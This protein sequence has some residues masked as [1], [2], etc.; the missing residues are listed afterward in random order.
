VPE[1]PRPGSREAETFT[2]RTRSW[3]MGP[4]DLLFLDTWVHHVEIV[5]E[6]PE[7]RRSALVPCCS[8][9]FS[10]GVTIL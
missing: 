5:W 1:V 8:I 4:I 10:T 9:P 6:I 7:F 2:S 3:G